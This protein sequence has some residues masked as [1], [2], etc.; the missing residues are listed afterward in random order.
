ML[1]LLMLV[2]DDDDD[3]KGKSLNAQ[4]NL[5]DPLVR[6]LCITSEQVIDA[7]DCPQLQQQQQQQQ[8]STNCLT[9][10]SVCFSLCSVVC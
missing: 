4:L 1:L 6:S 9:H 3:D 2:V 10:L 5:V 7:S 8:I